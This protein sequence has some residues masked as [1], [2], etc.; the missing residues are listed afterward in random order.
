MGRW[1]PCFLKKSL[2]RDNARIARPYNRGILVNDK[3]KILLE[4][5]TKRDYDLYEYYHGMLGTPGRKKHI[6]LEKIV[7]DNIVGPVRELAELRVKDLYIHQKFL[8][9]LRSKWTDIVEYKV[10][11]VNSAPDNFFYYMSGGILSRCKT[12][13][14]SLYPGWQDKS[15]RTLL[16]EYLNNL[17]QLQHGLCAIT[18]FPM[19]LK[20]R[21]E[22]ICSVDRIDS[23]KGY[24]PGNIWLTLWWVNNM[25]FDTDINT[26]L[27]R[28][29]IIHEANN[30][31][32]IA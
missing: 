11:Q 26:F 4:S 7:E 16:V 22:N 9:I 10:N 14:Q 17:Y 32:R 13:R 18:K 20:M 3:F 23:S 31:E 25:K 19:S 2:Q 8:A 24:E 27:E 28:V 6:M 12:G 1:H 29:K 21:S 5:F 30:V 15:G